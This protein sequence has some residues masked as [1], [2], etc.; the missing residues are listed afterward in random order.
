[1]KKLEKIILFF[2]FLIPL[3]LTLLINKDYLFAGKQFKTEDFQYTT[4]NT[5][6]QGDGELISYQN[7][8][9]NYLNWN[10]TCNGGKS[11][12]CIPNLGIYSLEL[13][14][15][16]DYI[17]LFIVTIITIFIPVALYGV[18]QTFKKYWRKK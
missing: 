5:P 7:Q 13:K 4:P 1:M 3:L 17:Y 6:N 8:K 9:N 10:R 16:T 15:L 18:Q 14:L 12:F 11:R 2:I